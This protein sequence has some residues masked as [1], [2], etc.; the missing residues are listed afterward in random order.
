MTGRSSDE[1]L[2]ISG[3]WPVSTIDQ[4]PSVV[5][6]SLLVTRDPDGAALLTGTVGAP[7]APP[8]DCEHFQFV[9][10]PGD[11]RRLIDFLSSVR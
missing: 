2:H 11:V 4:I 10:S 5:S 1:E 9:L 6:G 8:E 7:G 3:S